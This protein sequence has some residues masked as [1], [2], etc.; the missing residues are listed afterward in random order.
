MNLSE[1]LTIPVLANEMT[2]WRKDHGS[3][4]FGQ[5]IWNL[6]G[7]PGKAWPELFYE[8]N[9]LEAYSLLL[10]ALYERECLTP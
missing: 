9:E 7:M 6:Y 3:L 2:L 4:R 10:S 5:R 8:T 1:K